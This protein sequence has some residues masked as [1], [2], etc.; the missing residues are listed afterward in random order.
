MSSSW[1]EL[2]SSRGGD[3]PVLTQNRDVLHHLEISPIEAQVPIGIV[4]VVVRGFEEGA[5][6]GVAGRGAGVEPADAEMHVAGVHA[7]SGAVS[8]V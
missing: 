3:D 4:V 1:S 8:G 5:A 2:R 6:P 7:E